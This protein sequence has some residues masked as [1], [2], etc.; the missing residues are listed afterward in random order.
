MKRSFSDSLLEHEDA[1]MCAICSNLLDKP[2]SLS[3][4]HSTCKSC[5]PISNNKINSQVKC[6]ICNCLNTYDLEKANISISAQLVVS[7]KL[8]ESFLEV[9][10]NF[11]PTLNKYK[12]L[13][14]LNKINFR[15]VLFQTS[16]VAHK[17]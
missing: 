9:Q 11:A 17:E 15:V 3:C 5:I 14:F 8:N 7:L 6:K 13:S 16:Q 1:I 2:I 10:K 12:S 4:G